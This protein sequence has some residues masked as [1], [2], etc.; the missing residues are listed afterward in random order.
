MVAS[1]QIA[2][3]PLRQGVSL[4]CHRPRRP[5]P[6]HSLPLA[7]NRRWGRWLDIVDAPPHPVRVGRISL[8]EA[9][10]LPGARHGDRDGRG[11]P[12]VH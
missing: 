12:E 11:A 1:A 8:E 10:F 5:S 3:Y 2:I 4:A 7:S 6:T 9:A